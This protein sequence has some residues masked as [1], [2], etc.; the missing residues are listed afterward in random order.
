MEETSISPR[1]THALTLVKDAAFAVQ[2]ALI[3]EGWAV[4]AARR[5]GVTWERIGAVYGI[6]RQAAEQ[7]WH[8][9]PS[10][11]WKF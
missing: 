7:R 6:T 4:C 5:S 11:E 9:S 8:E 10:P 2:K 1:I 3:Q